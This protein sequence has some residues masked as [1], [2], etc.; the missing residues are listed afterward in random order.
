[1]SSASRPPKAEDGA[2]AMFSLRDKIKI[3]QPEVQHFV[4]ALEKENLRLAKQIAKLQAEI[5]T[6]NSRASALE[7][8][9]KI[10]QANINI[11]LGSD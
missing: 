6:L 2:S 7:E 3:E 5:V 11:D 10:T 9:T 4:A 1:M 8:S